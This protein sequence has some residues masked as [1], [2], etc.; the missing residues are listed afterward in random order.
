MYAV[1]SLAVCHLH[2][3]RT[4]VDTIVFGDIMI[5]DADTTGSVLQVNCERPESSRVRLTQLHLPHIL[6]A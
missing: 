6:T 2:L 5:F 4:V 1:Q 3:Q